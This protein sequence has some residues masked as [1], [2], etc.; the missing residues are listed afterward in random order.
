[1]DKSESTS[2]FVFFFSFWPSAA[3]EPAFSDTENFPH[4]DLSALFQDMSAEVNDV[5]SPVNDTYYCKPAAPGRMMCIQRPANFL[6]PLCLG[7]VGH[8]QACKSLKL[9][10]IQ[11]FWSATPQQGEGLCPDIPVT[12]TFLSFLCLNALLEFQLYFCDD[13][14]KGTAIS[15][16]DCADRQL[17]FL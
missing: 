12:V 2:F 8:S 7:K 10:W 3:T 11:S 16:S 9:R 1:M 5:L 4:V 6:S 13:V 15:G 14:W 17:S